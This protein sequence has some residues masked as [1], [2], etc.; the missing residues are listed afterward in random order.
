[1]PSDL[2][3]WR[4]RL[5]AKKLLLIEYETNL[6]RALTGYSAHS[7]DS[8]QMRQSITNHSIGQLRDAI[9]MLEGEIS[10]LEAKVNGRAG[11]GRP[12]W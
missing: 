6:S 10:T 4:Q 8:G 1:M 2:T 3:F 11:Q 9:S 7:L 12:A 5:E